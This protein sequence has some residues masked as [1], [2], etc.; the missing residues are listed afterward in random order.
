MLII[1][2][3]VINNFNYNNLKHY[4]ICIL[5]EIIIININLF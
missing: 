1:F 3:Y 4:N 5:Y 2:D